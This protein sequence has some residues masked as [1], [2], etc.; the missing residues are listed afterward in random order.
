MDKIWKYK[1]HYIIVI[2]ALLLILLFKIWPFLYGVVLSLK[3]YKPFMGLFG[4]EWVGLGNFS[5]LFGEPA[6]VQVLA[7]TLAMK[8]GYVFASAAVAFVVAL[9]L[10]AIP[11]NGLRQALSALFLFPF[12]IPSAVFASLVILTLSP[13]Q[14]PFGFGESFLLADPAS[15]RPVLILAETLKTCGVPI[16]IALA[17]IAAR[18]A[19]EAR[20]EEERRLYRGSFAHRNVYPALRAVSAYMLLQLSVLL[21]SDFELLLNLVNPLVYETGDMLDTYIYRTGLMNAQYGYAA[22]AEVL[23]VAIQFALALGA[24]FIVRGAFLSDLFGSREAQAIAPAGRGGGAAGLAVAAPFAAVVLAALYLLFVYPFAGGD[25]FHW[26]EWLPAGSTAA[27]LFINLAA[28]VIHLLITVTLAYP[29]T[30]KDLPGRG[31]Y[32]LFLLFA[33]VIGAGTVGEYMFFRGA[34]MVG[35]LFPQ[36]FSG[37]FNLAAVFV[38]KS[39]FNSKYGDLKE[40][41]AAEGRGELHTMITLFLP[42][43]WK[44]LLG[45]G[46]LQFIMLWN[47]YFTSLLYTVN[48]QL[49]SPMMRYM[50][51]FSSGGEALPMQQLL[52]LGALLSVPAVVL[53][54][55]LRKWLTSEVLL[56]QIRKL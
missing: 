15:F 22:A 26:S 7:N 29:L 9:A 11:S 17:A 36:L 27:Y 46:A 42:K 3:D 47:S 30:V 8:F 24:Y 2:P 40:K 43:I 14:S 18:H 19:S 13:S 31:L 23:Q 25:A 32:K 50:Q 44:P 34:G 45:L 49:H 39:I 37:F 52:Q 33:L 53:F 51:L 21:S 56:S 54:L 10:S 1:L 48:P 41:A 5:A 12:F 6:F 38:L 20:K 55:L 4:S 28:V 35:T 16:L